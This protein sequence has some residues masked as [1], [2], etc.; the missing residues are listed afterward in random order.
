MFTS[1]NLPK[2]RENAHATV[3]YCGGE[4]NRGLKTRHPLTEL[5]RRCDK[6][7][8]EVNTIS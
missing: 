2:L 4:M 8:G 3:A 1:E 5:S 7:R 6:E